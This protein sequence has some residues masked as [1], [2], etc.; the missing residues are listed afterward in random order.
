V[1]ARL[2][3]TYRRL[4]HR[5]A[6]GGSRRAGRTREALHLGGRRL[7]PEDRRRTE[8]RFDAA[9]VSRGL[10]VEVDEDQN[11][12]PVAFWDKP[13][14]TTVSGVPRGQQRAIYDRRKP[15]AARVQ[16]FTVIEIAWERRPPPGAHKRQDDR[17]RL[18]ELLRQ[19]GVTF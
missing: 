6:R 15:T 11:R 5:T 1:N 12:R 7:K 10:V 13:D 19:S 16:G 4:R 18:K 2:H 9:W 17:R 14:V 8:L 3:G